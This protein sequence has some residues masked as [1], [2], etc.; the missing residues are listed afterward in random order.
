MMLNQ[1]MR[2]GHDV[3]SVYDGWTWMLNVGTYSFFYQ[4]FVCLISGVA[5]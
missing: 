1:C 3:K 2:G 5:L 4:F